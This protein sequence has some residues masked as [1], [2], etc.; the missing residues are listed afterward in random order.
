MEMGMLIITDFFIHKGI[1]SL[2]RPR[3]R[4]EYNIEVDL[5]EIG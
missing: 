3:L 2:R 5:K 4:W 1:I